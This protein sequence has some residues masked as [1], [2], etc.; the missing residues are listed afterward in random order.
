L[1]P[2]A[3]GTGPMLKFNGTAYVA[4][5]FSNWTPI[6][7][8]ATSIGYDVAWKNTS[9]GVYTVWTLD[10]N[11]NFTSNLLSNVSGTGTSLKSIEITFQQDL[12]RDGVINTSSTVLDI[13]GKAVL[14]LPNISQPVTLEQD[15][16]L[17]LTGAASS[18]VTFK[19]ATG[20]LVLDHSMQFTGT[21]Y[22]LSGNGDPS[23]SNI[24]DLKDISFGS[25]TKIA[26]SGD[27][28]GGILTVS[29]AQNHTAQIKLAGDYTHSTFNL[30]SDGSGGT[31]VIDPPI[32]QFSFS[33]ARA[34][35]L[36]PTATH[37][38]AV[39]GDAFKFHGIVAA[40]SGQPLISTHHEW[41]QVL[42]TAHFGALFDYDQAQG[43][44]QI[45]LTPQIAP[46]DPPSFLLHV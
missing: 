30:S 4:G 29:D 16:V 15:A 36:P 40:P 38:S 24:L 12:N 25:G 26:Y 9:T 10:N 17:E 23:S 34:S 43:A 18:A 37:L 44:T 32:D 1:N 14:T 20:A 3:G 21:I 13:T 8:E 28:S 19:A 6:A 41:D 31:L 46:I 39:D 11:G 35:S 5:Q 42:S 2:A 45:E 33:G 7:A 22:G 27:T